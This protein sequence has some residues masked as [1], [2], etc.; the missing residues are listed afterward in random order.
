LIHIRCKVTHGFSYARVQS[1]GV[2]QHRWIIID[3]R[4]EVDVRVEPERVLGCKSS[5]GLI[6]VT[7]AI[8]VN[9]RFRVELA[10]SISE[11]IRRGTRGS[12]KIS[13][14]IVGV[15]VNQGPTGVAKRGN[16]A[17]SV[18]LVVAR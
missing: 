18:L 2:Y 12:G 4:V 15:G 10:T 3:I 9:S 7:G 11:R 1:V 6:V 8:I 5:R 17:K 13:E 14:R 16:R